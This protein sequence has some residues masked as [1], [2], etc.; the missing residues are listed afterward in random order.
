MVTVA[1]REAMENWCHQSAGWYPAVKQPRAGLVGRKLEEED[2]SGS[3]SVEQGLAQF[4]PVPCQHRQGQ[5]MQTFHELCVFPP[6]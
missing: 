6:T 4:Q 1:A 5:E 2:G 3:S